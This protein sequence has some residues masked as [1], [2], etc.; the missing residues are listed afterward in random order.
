MGDPPPD[1][2]DPFQQS[3]RQESYPAFEQQRSRQPSVSQLTVP[4]E[5]PQVTF[6]TQNL[7]SHEISASRSNQGWSQGASQGRFDNLFQA[8]EPQGGAEYL[9][10]PSDFQQQPYL[11]GGAQATH[12]ANLVLQQLQQGQGNI[13]QQLESAYQDTQPDF[14]GQYNTFQREDLEFGEDARH[15]PYLR[16]DPALEFSPSELGFMPFDMEVSE[17]EPRELAVQNAKAYLLQTS[18]NCDLSL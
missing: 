17:P 16:D 13:F 14:L 5:V 15:G 6:D 7:S 8:Q 2:E 10:I 3:L 1:P 9:S 11:E 12:N 4:Q 18:V